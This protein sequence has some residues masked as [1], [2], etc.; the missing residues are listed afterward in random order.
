MKRILGV[1]V[2]VSFIVFV[3]NFNNDV[4]AQSAQSTLENYC[5][6]SEGAYFIQDPHSDR[7]IACGTAPNICGIEYDR[8]GDGFVRKSNGDTVDW[9]NVNDCWDSGEQSGT[10]CDGW[11][12]CYGEVPLCC[13]LVEET[14]DP[15]KCAWPERG[16]CLERHCDAIPSGVDRM[17]CG[18]SI[19][20]WCRNDCNITKDQI[21]YI[22]LSQRVGG[23]VAPTNTPTPTSLI[24]TP[25]PT[26]PAGV[27]N[28]P[29]PTIPAGAT[30]TP[31]IVSGQPTLTPTPGATCDQM[32]L[33]GNF[34][35]TGGIDQ[36]DFTAWKESYAVTSSGLAFFEYWRRA[37]Y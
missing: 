7:E 30:V 15:K 4:Q 35:C 28:T 24:P 13:Y 3:S 23:A 11:G 9:H 19:G 25:T 17:N 26:T 31:T 16:Y 21:P 33:N 27:T 36:S 5:R 14:G 18:G 12:M 37:S 32:K 29:T 34:N 6:P 10:R 8:N 20:T 22:P 1:I 2:L